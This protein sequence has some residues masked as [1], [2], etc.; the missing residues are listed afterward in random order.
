MRV[1][2]GLVAVIYQKALILSNDE[3]GK[4]SGD[5]VNLMSV[6]A[7]RLQDLCAYGLMFISAPLQVTEFSSRRAN[8]LST[9]GIGHARICFI[10]QP[11]GMVRVCGSRHHDFLSSTEYGDRKFLEESSNKADEVQGQAFAPDE[12][13]VGEYQ[14][15]LYILGPNRAMSLD[16]D[17]TFSV[18]SIKL[19][20][21]EHAFLRRVLFVRNEEELKMLRKIGIFSVSVCTPIRPPVLNLELIGYR[22]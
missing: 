19:Y 8:S 9:F 10:V 14:E 21:W 6:D 5:I 20:A 22:R 16:I 2:T 7:S 11:P 12:R 3:R 15:V 18:F 13:I 4:A 1:R 17:R